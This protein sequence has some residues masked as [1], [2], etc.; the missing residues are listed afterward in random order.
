MVK[1]V[2]VKANARK[3]FGMLSYSPESVKKLSREDYNSYMGKDRERFPYVAFDRDVESCKSEIYSDRENGGYYRQGDF[4]GDRFIVNFKTSPTAI[5]DIA[6]DA[7]MRGQKLFDNTSFAYIEKDEDGNDVNCGL[8][9]F[10]MGLD[11]TSEEPDN[12]QKYCIALTRNSTAE[13]LEDREVTLI[14]HPEI[15]SF[16]GIRSPNIQAEPIY[17]SEEEIPPEDSTINLVQETEIEEQS[18]SSVLRESI[19]SSQIVDLVSSLFVDGAILK[20]S[21]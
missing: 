16:A 12:S 14:Y 1:Y 20:S 3:M 8:T 11:K 21:I 18:L 9:I 6:I 7:Q 19:K 4:T 13:N 10:R 17:S 5:G 15:F 2:A